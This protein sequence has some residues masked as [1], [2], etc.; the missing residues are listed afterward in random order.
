M[1]LSTIFQLY[2]GGQFYWWR[3]PPT[4]H[5][6]LINFIRSYQI[7][8]AHFFENYNSITN[9]DMYNT[10]LQSSQLLIIYVQKQCD[11]FSSILYMCTHLPWN[12]TNS[13]VNC[14]HIY[15]GMPQILWYIVYKFTLEYHKFSGI[16]CTNLALNATNSLVYCVQIYLEMPQILWYSAY[17]FTLECHKFSGV[18]CTNLLW[19]AIN[20]LVYY[21]QIYLGMP[22]ILW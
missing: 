7:N 3:K 20:S 19:N 18:L 8:E 14:V 15:L 16:Q 21:V 1:P 11:K 5:K 2:C 12:T 13:L 9:Y 4:C 10:M 17:K 22:Q 6:S